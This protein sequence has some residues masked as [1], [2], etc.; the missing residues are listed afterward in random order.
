M[1]MRCGHSLKWMCS[2]L[3]V[4][5]MTDA[6]SKIEYAGLNKN[7]DE[8]TNHVQ[9]CKLEFITAALVLDEVCN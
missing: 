1:A 3:R 6:A 5:Q 7:I 8:I 4:V 2:T 9:L